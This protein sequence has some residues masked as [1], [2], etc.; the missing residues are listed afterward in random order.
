MTPELHATLLRASATIVIVMS[1]VIL[2]RHSLSPAG[3][4]HALYGA[5]VAGWLLAMSMV[6]EAPTLEVAT[7]W[8]RWAMLAVCLLP[9]VVYQLNTETAGVAQERRRETIGY[10][11]ASVAIAMV[12]AGTPLILAE[13]QRYWWGYFPRFTAWGALPETPGTFSTVPGR[14]FVGSAMPFTDC[15]SAAFTLCRRAMP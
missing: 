4:G 9:G 3:R 5:T 13:P 7:T 10:H 15:S 11:A 1:A 6:A 8:S 2:T 14:T 12:G